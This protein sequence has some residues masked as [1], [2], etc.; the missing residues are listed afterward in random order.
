VGA[1]HRAELAPALRREQYRAGAAVARI[2]A[3]LH[4]P[5]GH[6]LVGEAGHVAAR[7]HQPSRQLPHL[8]PL[9]VP[10]QLR[11]EVEAG[12]RRAFELLAQPRSQWSLDKVGAREQPQPQA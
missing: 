7:H 12:Q 3:P 5:L 9:G 11:H 2:V 10:L 1:G 8:E 4:Q 6:Q